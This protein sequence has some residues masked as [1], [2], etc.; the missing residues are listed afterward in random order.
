MAT[1]AEFNKCISQ[2]MKGKKFSKEQRRQEFCILAKLCSSRSPNREEALRVCSNKTIN[3]VE[4]QKPYT[5]QPPKLR[6]ARGKCKI[7]I[8]VLA[9]CIIDTL[10]SSEISLARLIP[11]ISGCSG[12]KVETLSREKFIKKCFRENSITGDIKEAQKL[13]SM[14]T[15]AWKEQEQKFE[16]E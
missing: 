5:E 8:A 11:I 9:G 10:D 4:A 6:K 14:C 15:A 12:Q 7:D 2:G 3:K 1:R 13:R 16:K